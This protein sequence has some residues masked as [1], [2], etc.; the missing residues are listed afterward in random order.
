MALERLASSMAMDLGMTGALGASEP[1]AALAA[2][3]RGDREALER[4]YRDHF[5]TV[6][7]SAQRVLSQADAET[8][9]HEVFYR[10]ISS[11]ELR[12]SFRGGSLRA[13]ISTV[14]RNQAIDQFRRQQREKAVAAELAAEVPERVPDGS[15]DRELQRLVDAFRETLPTKWQG[16]FQA[17]FVEQRTQREAAARLG[18]HRTTLAY[19]ELQIRRRLLRLQRSEETA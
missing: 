6:V 13:W 3:H 10:P 16:V 12:A 18:I 5:E 11:A 7:A 4:C 2:F 1:D 14:A 9:V 8:A 15:D 17:R 19:Q